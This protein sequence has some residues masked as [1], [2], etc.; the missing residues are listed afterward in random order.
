MAGFVTNPLDVL[1]VAIY[2]G[3][4]K[5]VH[6]MIRYAIYGALTGIFIRGVIHLIIF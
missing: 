3:I 4:G 2:A 1:G 5:R 6:V